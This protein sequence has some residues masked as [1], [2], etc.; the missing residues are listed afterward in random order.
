ML[1]PESQLRKETQRA[2]FWIAHECERKR[3]FAGEMELFVLREG[4]G[5]KKSFSKED[6]WLKLSRTV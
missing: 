4:K 5:K 2:S 6:L 1:G 3:A